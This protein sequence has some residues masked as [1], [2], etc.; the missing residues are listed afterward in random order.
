MQKSASMGKDTES[1]T[2][3]CWTRSSGQVQDATIQ[4]RG[5]RPSE[6]RRRNSSTP[7]F[8]PTTRTS[9]KALR[10]DKVNFSHQGAA[11]QPPD[12][13]ADQCGP[14]R[15]AGRNLVLHAAAD[16][17]GRQQGAVVRQEP[18]AAA[19]DAAEEGHLQGCG[20][21]GRGQGR[22]EGDYRVP[23]RAAEV[24]EAGRA[25]SQGRAAGGPSGNGQDA[26]GAGCG[27]RGQRAVLLHLR[28]GLC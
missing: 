12:A 6:G 10:A 1:A 18:G 4:G 11:E 27:R 8:R 26:A 5:A 15:A 17:V 14:I 9:E 23:A 7:R 19:L 24:P 3:I 21:R 25:H 20:R 16:A 22:A 28:F 2:P 13:A